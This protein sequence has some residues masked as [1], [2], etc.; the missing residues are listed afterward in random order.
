MDM[1]SS[2]YGYGILIILLYI[3]IPKSTSCFEKVLPHHLSQ[4]SIGPALRCYDVVHY[5]L[6]YFLVP[7]KPLI[8]VS[9]LVPPNP[10]GIH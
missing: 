8:R 7:N 2:Y 10:F 4:L 6:V 3:L 1:G 9:D 5:C